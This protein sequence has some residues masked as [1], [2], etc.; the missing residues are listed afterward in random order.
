MPD[1]P[2]AHDKGYVYEHILVIEKAL[3][4]PLSQKAKAHHVDEDKS[5]NANTN[6]VACEDDAYH[7][8]LHQ[9]TRALKACGNP[10]KRQCLYCRQYDSV[11]RMSNKHQGQHY[12]R[13]CAA[14]YQYRRRNGRG[15]PHPTS[16]NV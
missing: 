8:L 6:L 14:D 3:G 13:T 11:I 16:Y 2:R 4:H 12:H 5:N 10:N 7:Q 15:N 9:R 1:H